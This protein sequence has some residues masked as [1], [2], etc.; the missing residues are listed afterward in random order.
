MS[1]KPNRKI[2]TITFRITAVIVI[3]SILLCFIFLVFSYMAFSRQFRA[4]YD[5]NI[6]AIAEAS[7]ECINEE[8]FPHYLETLECDEKYDAVKYI[9]QDF[10]D[11]FE[12]NFIYVS[13]VDPPDYTHI[14]YIYDLIK[15]DS[16]WTPY[17][18]GY[19]EDYIEPEYNAS[20]KKVFENGEAVVRHTIKA[21][22]GSHIAAMLP[23]RDESGKIIAVIGV[24][25]SIQSFVQAGFDF[26]KF[27]LITVVIFAFILFS[28]F[29]LFINKYLIHPILVI[30]EE[31]RHFAEDDPMP[32]DVLLKVV[33]HKDELSTLANSVRQMEYD[34]C[35][36]IAKLTKVTAEKERLSAE[37]NM[38]AK[39]QMDML[40][41]D[42]PPFPD[43]TDFDLCASMSPAKEV[44]GDLYDYMMLDDDRLLIC[45]GDVS[46]KGMPAALFMSKCKTLIDSFAS[47]DLTPGEIFIYTNNQLCAGNESGLF[48]TCWLGIF[49]FS[50]GQLVFVNAGHNAPVLY[51]NGT[52]QYLKTK[53]NLVLG[54]MDGISYTEHIV[55]LEKADR[56]LVYTD[57]VTEAE[58]EFHELFTDK[59]LK[60]CLTGIKDSDPEAMIKSIRS[61]IT[62]HVHGFDQFDDITMLCL[63][64]N[65]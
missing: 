32:S 14:T 62:S 20:A 50:T 1:D 16:T 31:V 56:L 35:R 30:T 45:V 11:K 7:L 64:Y 27:I 34:V 36:N 57:G 22:S 38:A 52:F 8:D 26:L 42:Y 47:S 5:A 12:L 65:G 37:V 63:K 9:L 54:G 2:S 51:Q 13:V 21:R 18:L 55:K 59:R 48:V 10:V 43:R 6:R 60:T 17:P 29:V 33:H 25:K 61:D 46:G 49:T 39:I 28:L 24:E 15:K 4:S 44:G 3:E 41:T 58:N 53:P 19:S 40:P 23:V